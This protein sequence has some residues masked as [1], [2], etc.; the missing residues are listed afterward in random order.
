M[1]KWQP[2]AASATPTACPRPWLA[3]VTKT[4]LFS[5][6]Q[7]AILNSGRHDANARPG[8][9]NGTGNK[10]AGRR[11]VAARQESAPKR[12]GRAFAWLRPRRRAFRPNSSC[13][14]LSLPM[15]LPSAECGMRG[16]EL[17]AVVLASRPRPRRFMAGEQVRTEHGASH[18]PTR[19]RAQLGWPG[20]VLEPKVQPDIC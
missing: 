14:R 12:V 10:K 2:A 3:P 11:A 1:S 6:L 9:V 17:G 16:A 5:I 18:E 8:L 19:E 13:W 15:N 20:V 4:I 7:A